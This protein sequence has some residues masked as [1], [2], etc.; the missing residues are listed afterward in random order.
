M[1]TP[2]WLAGLL[3]FVFFGHLDPQK[4]TEPPAEDHQ[5]SA[6]SGHG[7]E[8]V[9]ADPAPAVP[10]VEPAPPPEPEPEPKPPRMLPVQ[11]PGPSNHLSWDYVTYN[12]GDRY[13]PRPGMG[14]VSTPIRS[15]LFQVNTFKPRA[16]E[17]NP[18]L[19]F[20][21]AVEGQP[22][23]I[24]IFRR[25]D[26][27]LVYSTH[28]FHATGNS[29]MQEYDGKQYLTFWAGEPASGH[30]V[31]N[32]IMYDDEYQ[33]A[34]NLSINTFNT[35]ADSHEFQL[36]HDGGAMFSAYEAIRGYDMTPVGGPPD[37]VLQDSCFEEVDIATGE[38][39]FAWRASDWFSITETA[40]PY[41]DVEDYGHPT[42]DGGWDFFHINSLEKTADGNYLVVGRR[43]S[44]ITLINGTSGAPIWQVGGKNNQYRDLSDGMATS[45]GYQHHAR[46]VDDAQTEIVMFDN[47]D[48]AGTQPNPG[49]GDRCS[50][51]LHIKLNH[52]EKTAKLVRSYYHP[53]SVQSRAEG[54][55]EKQPNGN[56]L[57]GW[58]K[59][60]AFTE[61]TA[62]GEVLL[63]V[64]T[65]PWSDSVVGES[66]VYR[67]YSQDW[68]GNPKW[69]PDIAARDGHIYVSW[70]GATE[71]EYWAL[72]TGDASD[73]LEPTYITYRNG[74]ET[75]M[76][77]LGNPRYAR[78]AALDATGKLLGSTDR[79]DLETGL[80]SSVDSQLDI[81]FILDPHTLV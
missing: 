1:S 53:Y 61:Y 12:K 71:Q 44:M 15:P 33:L 55:A 65:G 3:T 11:Q 17:G 4:S 34:Y 78:V 50:R 70:N 46:F 52:E 74:F 48:L 62:D 22:G 79:I 6:G 63:D 43:L 26:L 76:P 45:F 47:S 8:D 23:T 56:L 29:R 20:C 67:I 75:T 68:R 2:A 13:G 21:P 14:Y 57:I 64:Q 5:D 36:T 58:G 25:K 16:T 9:V 80:K 59:V 19:F 77:I 31:G 51:G 30:G 38:T 66:H 39:R 18:Y 27:S 40:V 41:N 35:M 60:P 72:F 42:H 24:Q 7:M 69:N 10:E 73:S 54:G 49:C 37:G 81:D 28:G 32:G